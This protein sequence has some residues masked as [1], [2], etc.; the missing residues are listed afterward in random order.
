MIIDWE[1]HFLPLDLFRKFGGR[2]GEHALVMKEGKVDW[3][4]YDALWN[5]DLQLEFMDQSGIDVA[6]LTTGRS[7]SLEE[8]V[9]FDDQVSEVCRTHPGRFAS[10]VPVSPLNEAFFPEIE[11]AVVKMGFRGVVIQAQPGT[12]LDDRRMWPFYKEITRLDTVVFVHVSTSPPGFTAL[13]AP[14]DLNRSLA[15]ELDLCGAACRLILGGVLEAFPGL[16]IVFSH[17]G[18]GI[19]AVRDRV[20]RYVNFWGNRFWHSGHSPLSR[21]FS[22]YLGKLYFTMAGYEGGTNALACALTCLRPQQ[23]VFAT[24]Y[25]SNFIGDVPGVR[26]YVET[27]QALPLGQTDVDDMLGENAARLLKLYQ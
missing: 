23:L 3:S 4:P 19:A 2:Q 1:H 21:P 20:E 9:S 12:T 22:D 17:F 6:V 5:I 26:R 7:L 11:R 27:I 8:A 14:Y 18:G 25:P 15:R 16:K 10:L 13:D 24:D